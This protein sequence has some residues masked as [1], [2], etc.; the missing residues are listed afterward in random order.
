MEF[1][2]FTTI[3]E[4]NEFLKDYK[5]SD[6]IINTDDYFPIYRVWVNNILIKCPY[7][8]QKTPYDSTYCVCCGETLTHKDLPKLV[9]K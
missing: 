8:N 6:C 4:M 5:V 2:E 7:C 9:I 1:K 3:N